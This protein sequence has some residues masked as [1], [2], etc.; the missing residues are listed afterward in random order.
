MIKTKYSVLPSTGIQIKKKGFFKF[1]EL[2]KDMKSWF[3][4]HGYDF[5]EKEH[6]EKEKS[7]GKEVKI[8]W[9]AEREIDEYTKFY[10]KIEFF[11]ENLRK[12]DNKEIG[13]IKIT[14][15]SNIIFDYKKKWQ[16]SAIGKFLMHLYNNY[17]IKAKI[18][19]YYEPKLKADSYALHDL[20]KNYF[21]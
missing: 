9:E 8:V 11:I 13:N 17:L 19:S 6:S 7:I 10:I 2:Y 16:S 12:E 4:D 1:K 18:F 3:D 21:E 15:W 20:A 5:H 14:F